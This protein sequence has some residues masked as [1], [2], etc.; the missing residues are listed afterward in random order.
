MIKLTEK[1]FEKFRNLIHKVTGIH[2]RKEKSTLIESRLAKRLRHFGIK[3]YSEYYDRLQNDAF[4]LQIFIDT[5]TTNETSFFREPHHFEFLKTVL[6]KRTSSLRIW[7]AA[8][9][10]G[11]EAYSAAMVCDEVLG[12]KKIGWDILCSDINVDVIEQA[13]KGLY[14]NKFIP[15]ISDRYLKQHCLKG[16]G[17]QEGNFLIEDHLKEHLS[18]KRL[19]LMEAVGKEVGEFDVIFLR[20]MLIYFNNPERKYIVEN[21]VSRLKKGGYLLIGH[22]ETLFNITNCV[23]QVKPTIYI[24]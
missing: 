8:C 20:N 2:M 11:A 15:Q 22:S 10:I 21:V 6:S 19:N 18:F 5:I 9:S 14:P 24:K 4:E 7:S 1:E 3:T 23:K 12:P 13:K 17:T 16:F